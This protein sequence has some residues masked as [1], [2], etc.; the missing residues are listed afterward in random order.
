VWVVDPFLREVQVFTSASTKRVLRT[1][2]TLDGG[3]LLPSLKLTV[4]KVFA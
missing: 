3:S 1:G 2:E 4:A